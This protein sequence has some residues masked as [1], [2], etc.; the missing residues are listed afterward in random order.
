MDT[1]KQ[2]M[3]GFH[4]INFLLRGKKEE[5]GL[6]NVDQSERFHSINFLLRGKITVPHRASETTIKFPFY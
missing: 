4:S 1:V 6:V 5:V 3:T 2:D